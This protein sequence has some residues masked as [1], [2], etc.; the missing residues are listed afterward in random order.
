MEAGYEN[1]AE[2]RNPSHQLWP[3]RDDPAEARSYRKD[4]LCLAVHLAGVAAD[5]PLLI[6]VYV[7]DTHCLPPAFFTPTMHSR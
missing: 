3:N 2:F 7:I 6:L 4:I 1:K 5:A